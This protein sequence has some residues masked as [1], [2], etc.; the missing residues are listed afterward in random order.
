MVDGVFAGFWLSHIDRARLDEFLG[1]V[2]RWLAPGGLFAFIDSR[3][4]AESGAV[5]HRP[6]AADV[7]GPQAR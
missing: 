4:D 7:Q 3:Q 2:G 1:L 5:D 6:P